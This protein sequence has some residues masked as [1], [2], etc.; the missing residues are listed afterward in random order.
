MGDLFKLIYYLKQLEGIPGDHPTGTKAE[1]CHTELP[2]F[3]THT[4][5]NVATYFD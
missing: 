5:N 4:L 1:Y 2:N 3:S